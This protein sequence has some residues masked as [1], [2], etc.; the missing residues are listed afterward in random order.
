MK[1]IGHLRSRA[2]IA[3]VSI[4]AVATS[5]GAATVHRLAVS[6]GTG[7][8]GATAFVQ[9]GASSSALQGEVASSPNT[10][11]KIP[12]GVL[13]DYDIAGTTF[14]IGVAG[15]STTGY[16]VGAESFSAMNP[17]LLAINT[18]NANGAEIYGEGSSTVESGYFAQGASGLL[19]SS[20]HGNAIQAS[21]ASDSVATIYSEDDAPTSG[22]GVFG[23]DFSPN[24]YGLF[25][26]G[27]SGVGADSETTGPYFPA[28]LAESATPGTELYDGILS[29][30]TSN[31]GQEVFAVTTPSENTSGTVDPQGTGVSSDLQVN[32]D[33][34]ISGA[35]YTGCQAAPQ[36]TDPATDCASSTPSDVAKSANGTKYVTYAAKH[37]S[38]TL[39]D[40]GE[41]RLVNGYAHVSLDP[42]YAS[43]I[44]TASPYLV[45][46]T[47]MGESHGLY[48]ANR[49]ATGFDVRENA[50]GRSS[51][52]FDYRIVAHPYGARVARMAP[53]V[54]RHIAKRPMT[55]KAAARMRMIQQRMHAR[56]MLKSHVAPRSFASYIHP[57]R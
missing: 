11:I 47:P 56:P 17:S 1:F 4:V 46:T 31:G 10:S 36:E 38:E 29:S 48:V 43:T 25:G 42:A 13:G 40:E 7:S 23:A 19:T 52:T 45:F 37:A 53:I 32:G 28:V 14:G 15:V 33:I 39:E 30:S 41:A 2:G 51:M 54:H 12:F 34:Y 49:T 26:F 24:G 20:T 5:A 35:V 55:A 50:A 9:S 6:Q 22:I 21:T 3:A 18:T 44:S 57:T 27:S 16:G 8:E